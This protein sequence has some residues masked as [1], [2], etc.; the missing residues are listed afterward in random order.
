VGEW[1]Y[2]STH[3]ETRHVTRVSGH[4]HAPPALLP[5]KEPL[6][7]IGLEAELAPEAVSTR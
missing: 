4:L 5:R 1:K 6:V 2:S 3:L 7:P